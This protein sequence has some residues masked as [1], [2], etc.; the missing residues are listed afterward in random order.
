[1]CI[2]DRF[3]SVNGSLIWLSRVC[4]PDVSYRVS[5]L[6][7]RLKGLKVA[8][9]QESNKVIAYA[10]EDPDKGLTFRSGV[11]DWKAMCVGAI[12]DASHGEE[13]AWVENMKALEPYRSQGGRLNI[14]A[15]TELENGEQC[16]FHL[17][18]WSS[19]VIKRVVRSTLQGESYAL[20]NLSL[21]HI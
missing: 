19:N 14:L 9:L 8:D 18:S 3:R 6:Q 13:H 7:Q 11:I 17:I 15:T 16:H 12:T 10:K 1:M 4:R 2:R 21:I 20:Q 5:S